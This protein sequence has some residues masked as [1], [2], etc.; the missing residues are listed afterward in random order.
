MA[1]IAFT[2]YQGDMQSCISWVI[3]LCCHVAAL[4]QTLPTEGLMYSLITTYCC[5]TAALDRVLASSPCYDILDGTW[6][7]KTGL[8]S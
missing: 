6:V 2:S 4:F 3:A 5:I 1:R 8:C 7:N